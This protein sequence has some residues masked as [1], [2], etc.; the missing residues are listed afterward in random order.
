[1]SA[2]IYQVI[3]TAVISELADET[4]QQRFKTLK[5]VLFLGR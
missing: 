1:M 5:V 4:M 2:S 3:N